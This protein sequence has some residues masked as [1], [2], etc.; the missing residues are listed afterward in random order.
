MAKMFYSLEETAKKLGIDEEQVKEM[1]AS[2]EIQQFRDRD[3][4]MFKR[5]QI[6][7]LTP[8]APEELG[9][10]SSTLNDFVEDDG[11]IPWLKKTSPPHRRSNPKQQP[12]PT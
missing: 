3:K 8:D 2:G 1:A 10:L 11:L 9:D 5:E 7:N 6:D 4:L 12:T